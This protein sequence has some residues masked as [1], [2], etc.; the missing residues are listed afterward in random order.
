MHP[1]P[2]LCAASTYEAARSLGARYPL[3]APWR[4]VDAFQA[5]RG[6]DKALALSELARAYR[7]LRAGNRLLSDGAFALCALLLKGSLLRLAVDHQEH[8]PRRREAGPARIIPGREPGELLASL[9]EDAARGV[10]VLLSGV[11][12]RARDKGASELSQA[13]LESDW[14]AAWRLLEEAPPSRPDPFLLARLGDAILKLSLDDRQI[15]DLLLSGLEPVEI[16]AALD[17]RPS[18]A[19]MRVKRALDRLRA[20]LGA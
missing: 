5:L 17:L 15:V 13:R 7:E 8:R 1:L 12:T 4:T 11:V 19:R 14:S 18:A 20:L 6:A 3:L 16:G 9:A 10:P 2:I